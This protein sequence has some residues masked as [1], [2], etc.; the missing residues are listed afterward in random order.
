M[1]RQ[2]RD[3]RRDWGNWSQVEQL[4]ITM[5]ALFSLIV[6]AFGFAHS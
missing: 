4:A 1:W 3:F 5:V 6:I 2:L